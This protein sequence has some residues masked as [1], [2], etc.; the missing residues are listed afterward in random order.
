MS[1]RQR[2]DPETRRAE[3]VTAAAALFAERGVAETAVSDIVRAAGVAQGTFYLYFESKDAIVCAVAEALI[4]DMVRRI[5]TALDDPSHSA[6]EKLEAMALALVEI[7]DEPYE[8][9]L[10]SI[11]HQPD[12][13]AFHDTVTRSIIARLM[14]HLA[15][16]IEQGVAE[17]IFIAEDPERS[18]WFILGALQGLELGFTGTGEVRA[19]VGQ[20]RAFVL[21]GLGYSGTATGTPARDGGAS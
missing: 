18:A 1:A 21:R 14:P 20:L 2:K 12:N 5:E 6:V 11:F 3:L 17:G 7:N 16:I 19:A 8:I 13:L 4:D 10:M 9:E 15:R